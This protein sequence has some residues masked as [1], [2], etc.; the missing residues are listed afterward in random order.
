MKRNYSKK[1][2]SRDLKENYL[3]QRSSPANKFSAYSSL[4]PSMILKLQNLKTKWY[5]NIDTVFAGLDVR[6]Y[7]L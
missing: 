1:L 6:F 5:Y 7:I 2:N 4:G 3:N